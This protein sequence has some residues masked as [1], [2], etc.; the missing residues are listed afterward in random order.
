[1]A[2]AWM[3]LF[4]HSRTLNLALTLTPPHTEPDMTGKA[5]LPGHGLG[6]TPLPSTPASSSSPPRP[7]G[8][9]GCT[10]AELT[11]W[12]FSSP[13]VHVLS[14][15]QACTS[16]K[17]ALSR[18]QRRQQPTATKQHAR[19][20]SA[21][22][23]VRRQDGRGGDGG[24]LGGCSS[25]PATAAA[26]SATAS[27]SAA[28]AVGWGQ[29]LRQQQ[30]PTGVRHTVP[31]RGGR[32]VDVGEGG[33]VG[34]VSHGGQVGDVWGSS[35]PSGSAE[36]AVARW[37]DPLASAVHGFVEQREERRALALGAC[38]MVS[39]PG[40]WGG[41]AEGSEASAQQQQLLQMQM[42][43]SGMLYPFLP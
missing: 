36:Q 29:R 43:Q 37:G 7:P 40:G 2:P 39:G 6:G 8:L 17:L 5:G 32:V 21:A 10:P 35:R 31:A 41:G 30:L 16:P 38:I 18:P 42:R 12:P 25:R 24:Y 19:A 13:G 33:L 20:S 11:G 27:A 26:A 4:S 9:R 15:Q 22:A 34:G 14:G 1:M 23:A 3:R 28:L